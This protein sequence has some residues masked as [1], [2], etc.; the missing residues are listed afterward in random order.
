MGVDL[1]SLHQTAYG[2]VGVGRQPR[3]FDPPLIHVTHYLYLLCT[4]PQHTSPPYKTSLK[5]A[6]KGPTR[7]SILIGPN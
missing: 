2:V 3:N 6:R 7:P 5:W 1:K 4:G